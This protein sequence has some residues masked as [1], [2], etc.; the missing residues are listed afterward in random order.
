MKA[1]LDLTGQRYGRLLVQKRSKD[2]EFWVCLCDCGT[3]RDVKQANL[4]VGVTRSCGC[5]FRDVKSFE[6]PRPWTE[7]EV[8]RLR[9]EEATL[10]VL[11]L[12]LQRTRGDVDRK[13]RELGLVRDNRKRHSGRLEAKHTRL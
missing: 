12:E 7:A 11:A 9:T 3:V 2:P 13:R 4:R 1:R 8:E 6:P 5:L 10:G